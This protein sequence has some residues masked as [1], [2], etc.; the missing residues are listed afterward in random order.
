M[1]PGGTNIPAAGGYRNL[2]DL[3]YHAASSPGSSRGYSL[4][5]TM[6]RAPY[7]QHHQ[8]QP[9]HSPNVSTSPHTAFNPP[10]RAE[11]RALSISSQET[12]NV[13]GNAAEGKR[14]RTSRSGSISDA[15][16]TTD[17]GNSPQPAKL[18]NPY[19]PTSPASRQAFR[20]P[21]PYSGPSYPNSPAV[22]PT[23]TQ[24]GYYSQAGPTSAS[25]DQH[26]S[27]APHSA[28]GSPQIPSQ[29]ATHPASSYQPS[30][31]SYGDQQG[32]YYH[33]GYGARSP[34]HAGAPGHGY[35]YQ[36]QPQPASAEGYRSEY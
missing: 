22:A 8:P 26:H 24:Y 1:E 5:P 9:H 18:R 2:N 21:M 15:A 6:T 33:L 17:G 29:N 13:Y 34:N 10:P 31:T 19:P 20:A 4:S 30:T 35:Y 32:M 16:S 7:P 14:A 27:H 11:K 25:V 3:A 28:Y 12:P 23:S 36:Q